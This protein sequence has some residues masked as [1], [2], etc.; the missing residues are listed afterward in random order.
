MTRIQLPAV[1][2]YIACCLQTDHPDLSCPSLKSSWP[3][4]YL[5]AILALEEAEILATCA[6]YWSTA[7]MTLSIP[8]I[9][10]H[11]FLPYYL[12]VLL[13]AELPL[14]G[15]L[16]GQLALVPPAL[17]IQNSRC[18]LLLFCG[19]LQQLSNHIYLTQ[20]V[21]GSIPFTYMRCD[22]KQVTLFSK[23]SDSLFTK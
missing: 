22:P 9:S 15:P 13:P 2:G 12:D 19:I 5:I 4:E 20:F 21:L 7:C 17:W 8:W 1:W 10:M 16:F 3:C 23:A 18:W 14:P 6:S 11:Y